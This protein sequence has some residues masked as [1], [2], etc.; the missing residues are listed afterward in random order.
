MAIPGPG[1]IC[2]KGQL[3]ICTVTNTR[4]VTPHTGRQEPALLAVVC[5]WGIEFRSSLLN[6]RGFRSR[7][8][9]GRPLKAVTVEYKNRLLP[10]SDLVVGRSSFSFCRV[11]RRWT[12]P[13]CMYKAGRKC[14]RL[15]SQSQHVRVKQAGTQGRHDDVDTH[16]PILQARHDVEAKV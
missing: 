13:L 3:V 15:S 14:L 8:C 9:C 2:I 5:L 10:D 12:L 16:P 11:T 6:S 1:S 4:P 7:M